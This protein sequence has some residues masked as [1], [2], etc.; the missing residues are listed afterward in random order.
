LEHFPLTDFQS[1]T[2][3][4]TLNRN[5]LHPIEV[6]FP[7]PEEQLR[8]VE[9]LRSGDDAIAATANVLQGLER[10]SSEITKRA[11]V[12]PDSV[13]VGGE[14]STFEDLFDIKGGSQPPKSSFIYKPK[15][16][17]ARLLQI[18]DFETDDKAV[19]ISEGASKV[20]CEV[21]DILI[22]RYGASVGR[23]LTG[24][25]GAYNV[26]LTKVV[27]RS[28]RIFRRFAYHW[29]KSEYFQNRIKAVSNR[30]AQAGFNKEDLFPTKVSL[31]PMEVQVSIA[32]ALDDLENAISIN[33]AFLQ[34][35]EATKSALLTDLITG[36]VRVPA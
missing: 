33:R 17:Y 7:P 9:V 6:A 11:F 34:D 26:A 12:D 14:V 27:F 30:S 32:K 15:E 28:N 25:A 23:I 1:G 8:I 16:G 35:A 18:R 24:K 29:L 13:E 36:R 22:A 20:R 19:F 10:V 4:P 3:V 2:G 31:P 21:G 5:D